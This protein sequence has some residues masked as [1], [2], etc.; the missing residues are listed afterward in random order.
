M[1]EKAQISSRHLMALS[2]IITICG[3]IMIFPTEA[4]EA[5]GRS[6]WLVLIMIGASQFISILTVGK[7]CQKF[8]G[9]TVT[10]FAGRIAGRWTGKIIGL[11][12]A[13]LLALSASSDLFYGVKSIVGPF[14]FNTPSFAI[15]LTMALTGLS[16]TWFGLVNASRM[17]PFLMTLIVMTTIVVFLF[18]LKDTHWGYL[19]PLFNISS[20]HIQMSFWASFCTFRTSVY[21][22]AIMPY[23]EK[24]Q[25]ALQYYCWGFWIGWTTILIATL[26]PLLLFGPEGAKELSQPFPYVISTIRI[27]IIPFEHV[28]IIAR[29][30]YNINVL[31]AIGLSYFVGGR[32]LADVF[33]TKQIRPFMIVLTVISIIPRLFA[34]SNWLGQ[35]FSSYSLILALIMIWIIF[36]SLWIIYWLRG[37]SKSCNKPN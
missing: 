11:S 37:I 22:S 30:V 6:A 35:A 29:L 9:M 13:V 5:S 32:L 16:F 19:T 28:E 7:L 26:S 18:M 17:S 12:I 23:I 24:P 3:S 10:Q 8:P 36:P 25:S 1:N 4:I 2:A 15:V 34:E 27:P 31:L 33:N 14:F 20:I 21:L